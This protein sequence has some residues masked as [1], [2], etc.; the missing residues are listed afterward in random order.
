MEDTHVALIEQGVPPHE[1]TMTLEKPF[2]ANFSVNLCL[3][4]LLIGVLVSGLGLGVP[5]SIALIIIAN[6]IGALPS[7]F[8]ALMG[9]KTRLSQL[10]A[11]RLSFGKNGKRLPAILNW[12]VCIGWDAIN[13]IP[14]V[15]A[16][17]ALF[18]YYGVG[19]KYWFL[20]AVMV[21]IQMFIG[22]YGHHLTQAIQKYAGYF[23][24]ILLLVILYQVLSAKNFTVEIKPFSPIDTITVFA[25][26]MILL[27]GGTGDASDYTRYLPAGTKP[28]KIFT[29][30]FLG[31]S[32]S[33]ILVEIL[34]YLMGTALPDQTPQAVITE[35]Q[36]YAGA[37]APL[38]LFL[39]AITAIPCNAINDNSASY[40][41]ISAGL[42]ISR[43]ISAAIGAIC[44]YF[45]ALSGPDAFMAILE[46]FL[47]FLFYW[48]APW[49]AIVLVHW[50]RIGRYQE[51]H[52]YSPGWTKAA[53]IFVVT[54]IATIALFSASPIYTS[55]VA[56]ALG[57]IDIGY[58]VGFVVAGVWYWLTLRKT[59]TIVAPVSV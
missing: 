35:I 47:L 2:W 12:I 52:S 16:L 42:H 23:L 40:C 19:T 33:A 34:G 54:T 50:F 41:L 13:N 8:A 20:L 24:T 48:V 45:L 32:V 36:T 27:A 9:P 7:A 26:V 44:S 49:T 29:R 51:E 37:F 39:I 28:A 4:T 1:Q 31:L 6:L 46:N 38:V 56:K 10:E 57:G 22:I 17:V 5:Y 3:A 58:Y 53:T 11:T 21:I 18:A 15:L 59:P 43:P 55:P 14:S 30:V 25:S